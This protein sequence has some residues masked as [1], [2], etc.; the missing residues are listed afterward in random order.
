MLLVSPDFLAS[1][2]IADHELPPLLRAAQDE[3]VRIL[4][5]LIRDCLFSETEIAD[6]HE[7]P[8]PEINH[9]YQSLPSN[10]ETEA[11]ISTLVQFRLLR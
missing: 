11:K 9:L 1:D 8:C 4:W 2:F 3:G 5:V 10:C 6:Y 7:D